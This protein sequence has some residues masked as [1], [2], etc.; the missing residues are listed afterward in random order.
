MFEGLLSS[1]LACLEQLVFSH[2]GWR[3]NPAF[4]RDR[5]RLFCTTE[6]YSFRRFAWKPYTYSESL[7]NFT[8]RRLCLQSCFET[9][10][11]Y[12]SIES[13]K[14]EQTTSRGFTFHLGFLFWGKLYHQNV[15]FPGWVFLLGRYLFPACRLCDRSELREKINNLGAELHRRPNLSVY[16]VISICTANKREKECNGSILWTFSF[17]SVPGVCFCCS[18]L[19]SYVQN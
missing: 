14:C 2:K 7:W 8:W 11:P 4:W 12:L 13:D 16:I 18:D 15:F 6:I 17:I 9:F 5:V 3:Q 1:G 19:R 10:V